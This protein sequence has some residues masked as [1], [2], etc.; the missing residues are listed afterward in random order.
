MFC[1]QIFIV[2]NRIGVNFYL[3]SIFEDSFDFKE[4]GRGILEMSRTGPAEG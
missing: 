4:I 1:C 3:N 2:S